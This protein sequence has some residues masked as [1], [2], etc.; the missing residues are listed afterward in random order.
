MVGIC[1]LESDQSGININGVHV[2]VFDK[3]PRRDRG[4]TE[5]VLLMHLSVT[6]V[7]PLKDL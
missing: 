7:S 5:R 6:L 2:Q 1:L 3:Q 4:R